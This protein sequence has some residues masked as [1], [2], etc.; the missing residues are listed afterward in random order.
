MGIRTTV[1]GLTGAQRAR[2]FGNCFMKAWGKVEAPIAYLFL[3]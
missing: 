2:V 1:A 3:L